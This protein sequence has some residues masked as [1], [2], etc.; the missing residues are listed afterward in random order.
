MVGASASSV[1]PPFPGRPK[2]ALQFPRA[3][4]L[5]ANE[6]AGLRTLSAEL[7]DYLAAHGYSDEDSNYFRIA[8]HELVI[9]ATKHVPDQQR[10]R[11]EVLEAPRERYNYHD[12]LYVRV[13]DEGKGFDFDTTLAQLEQKLRS[14]QVEHGLL[15]TLRLTSVLSQESLSPHTM[16]FWKERVPI[17]TPAAFL[18]SRVFPIVFDYGSEA[19]RFGSV[20]HTFFQF[21]KYLDRSTDFLAMIFDPLLCS[22]AK[23]I[24]IE[25]LGQGWTGV[26]QWDLV[27]DRIIA[28]FRNQPR[29]GRKILLFAETGP[30]DHMRLRKYCKQN[31]VRLF[32]N[33]STVA[34]FLEGLK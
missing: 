24:G 23:S 17:P 22:P 3:Y 33:R 28:F 29:F 25:I 2:E 10:V 11:V 30:S 32:E 21:S 8:L 34:A 16:T 1:L 9:N 20:G 6:P 26:L 27:L 4:E 13:T 12:S 31:S 15:R 5:H 14:D 18:D 7:T 19:I